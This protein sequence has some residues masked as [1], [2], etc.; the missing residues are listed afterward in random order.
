MRA[1][2]Q[3]WFW[4][5]VA[6]TGVVG[7]WG[8]LL[9]LTK[10]PAPRLFFHARWVAFGAMAIQVGAG[11]ILYSRGMRSGND[12]HI[13]YGIVIA[14]VFAFAYIYRAALARRPELGYGLL[15]LF[16]MG[17]GFRAWSNVF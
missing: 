10:R 15:L 8:L 13:F 2:H 11:L 14:F 4:V 12:F 7:L 6:T 1:F 9:G 17:L 3:S 16:I 5:A